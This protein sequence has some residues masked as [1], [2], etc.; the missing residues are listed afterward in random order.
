MLEGGFGRWQ[1]ET[2]GL[3]DESWR[4]E[5]VDMDAGGWRLKAGC[6]QEDGGWRMKA[7]RWRFQ[8]G[9]LKLEDGGW[10][11]CSSAPQPAV[12]T[13]AVSL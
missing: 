3:E 6:L 9:D 5:P 11:L 7:G 12:A 2:G 4:M 10:R 1:M 8:A 13:P